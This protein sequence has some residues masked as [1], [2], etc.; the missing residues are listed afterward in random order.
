MTTQIK[1]RKS[2]AA[3]K[4]ALR[5]TLSNWQLY[6]M[7][8]PTVALLFALNYMPMFGTEPAFKKYKIS[9]G[10]RGSDWMQLFSDKIFVKTGQLIC[11]KLP[12]CLNHKTVRFHS[13]KDP[14]C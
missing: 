11:Q 9:K 12:S 14:R 10:I 1:Q 2:S 4:R 13:K 6:L 7:A 8:L 5:R 3:G